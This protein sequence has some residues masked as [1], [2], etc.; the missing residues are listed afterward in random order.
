MITVQ[1]EPCPGAPFVL[2]TDGFIGLVYGDPRGPY[3][4]ANPHQGLDIFSADRDQPGL[5]PV[6]AAYEGYITRNAG[7]RSALIQRVPEDPLDPSRQIWLYYAHMADRDGNDFIE[8]PFPAGSS[9]VFVEQGTLLGY[10]GNFNGSSPRAIWVHL[11]FS[12]VQDDGSGS[13]LNELE[14]ENTLDP[15]NYLGMP[16]NYNCAQPVPACAAVTECS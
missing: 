6:Y 11:H 8:E 10:T 7:W 2:P 1:R 3:S 15:T 16:L 9:E 5:M 12:I 14:F 13:Y 4:R